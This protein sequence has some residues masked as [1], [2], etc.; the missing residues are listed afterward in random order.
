[1]KIGNIELKTPAILAPMAGVT[2][3]PYRTICKEMGASIV[4]TEFVSADGIIRENIKTL[5]MISFEDFERPIGVQIFGNDPDTVSNSAK[6]IYKNYQPDI[7]DINFGCPVPK[8]TKRG[9]GSAALKDLSI[10]REL[11]SKVVNAVPQIPITVKMRSGWDKNNIIISEAGPILE[12][13]G[14]QAITLHARTSKQLYSGEADWNLIKKLKESVNIPVIGNGD[15]KSIDDYHS[16]L[17][18]TKCDAV[19]IGRAALGNP[20]IFKNIQNSINDLP[21]MSIGI[22]DITK[23]CLKHI[24]LLEKHKSS[25]ACLNLSKKHINYYLKNFKNSSNYRKELMRCDNIND[26][27][28]ILK[29]IS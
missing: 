17:K 4:Y 6:Y 14:I 7:I 29:N 1:M 19:M 23:I 24:S 5:N 13:C 16:I 10:M 18:Q 11:A 12:D 15:V 28:K 25:I 21:L 9:A 22:K 2:D 20:W 8:V 26:I 3:L 27:K